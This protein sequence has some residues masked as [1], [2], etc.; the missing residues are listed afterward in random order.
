MSLCLLWARSPSLEV[1]LVLQESRPEVVTGSV[2]DRLQ[3]M[4]HGHQL[5]RRTAAGL[6]LRRQR[7]PQHDFQAL[8]E[9]KVAAR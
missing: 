1:T 3:V 2:D 4:V 7:F 9:K 8:G 6:W 5:R